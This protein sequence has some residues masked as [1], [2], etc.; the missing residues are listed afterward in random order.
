MPLL[1][2]NGLLEREKWRK[3]GK[4]GKREEETGEEREGERYKSTLS[5]GW[6]FETWPARP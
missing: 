4:K 5:L 2:E 3:I 6:V 1:W